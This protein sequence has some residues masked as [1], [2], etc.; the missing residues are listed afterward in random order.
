MK[1]VVHLRPVA[2]EAAK[3]PYPPTV[4]A[5]PHTMEAAY[6]RKAPHSYGW[7]I[8]PRALSAGLWRPVSLNLRA[9]EEVETLYLATVSVQPDLSAADL[10]LSYTL[11]LPEAPPNTYE[12]RLEAS[13]GNRASR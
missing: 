5:S 2:A 12:L 1:V 10:L 7:D 3:Y 11:R 6:I 8:M 9:A 4:W 13:A